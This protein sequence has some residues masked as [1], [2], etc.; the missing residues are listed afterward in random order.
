MSGVVIATAAVA[1]ANSSDADGMRFADSPQMIA[2]AIIEMPMTLRMST[3]RKL[4]SAPQPSSCDCSRK[5]NASAKTCRPRRRA[6]AAAAAWPTLAARD[7]AAIE[8]VRPARNRNS[9]AAMPAMKTVIHVERAV[10]IVERA[11]TRR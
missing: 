1:I 10:A 9:G 6:S 2:A 3:F 5:R 4:M 8:I 7:E 11:S